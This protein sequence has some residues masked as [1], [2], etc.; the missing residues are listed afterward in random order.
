MLQLKNLFA[1][2]PL[3]ASMAIESGA[4]PI[5]KREVPQGELYDALSQV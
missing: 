3:L 1:L 4:S 2:L 5:A